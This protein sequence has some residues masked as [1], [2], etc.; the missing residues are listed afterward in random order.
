MNHP[1]RKSH[2][3][4]CP[5]TAFICT[6]SVWQMV[7]ENKA[8]TFFIPSLFTFKVNFHTRQDSRLLV[9]QPQWIR[10]SGTYNQNFRGPKKKNFRGPTIPHP[11]ETW[12]LFITCVWECV[13][14]LSAVSVFL[15]WLVS[16]FWGL[17]KL[18]DNLPPTG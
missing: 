11:Q 14:F 15:S 13:W 17:S 10:S 3:M 1:S 9:S 2:G 7:F 5:K 4:F 12:P 18:P 16:D 8:K 6:S